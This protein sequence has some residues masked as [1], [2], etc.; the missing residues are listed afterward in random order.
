[1]GSEQSSPEELDGDCYGYRILGMQEN[2]PASTVGFVSFFDFIVACNGI[3]LD[4][5]DNT[6]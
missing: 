5:R 3:R 2:S 1:M 4:Q 6:V